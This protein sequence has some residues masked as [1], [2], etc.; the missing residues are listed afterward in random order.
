M[1]RSYSTFSINDCRGN[2]MIYVLVVIALFAALAFVVSRG[3][4]TSEASALDRE[5]VNVYASQIIQVSNQMKQGIDQMV[6]SGSTLNAL[7]FCLPGEIC[8][9]SAQN[10][11][12]QPDGGGMIMPKIP[13][14][15]INAVDSDP[16]PGWYMGRFNNVAWTQTGANDILFVA[17]QI[18][19]D[20]CAKINELL[21][22]DATIPPLTVDNKMALID[23]ARHSGGAN[24]ALDTAQCPAGCDGHLS[25]C[26]VNADGTIW[27]YY[28]VI[29]PQ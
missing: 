10:R 12:F 2:A 28:N 21:V 24:V 17:H 26:V 1:I 19:Q 20:V 15:A 5:K 23:T 9:S 13:P 8:A 29:G 18:R 25:L 14:E 4:D 3:G 11:A 6:W 27:T 22:N 16:A 7:D